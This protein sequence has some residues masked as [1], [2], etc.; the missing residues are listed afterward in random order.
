MKLNKIICANCVDIIDEF[1]DNSIKLVATS[2][3]YKNAYQSNYT[4][5]FG[6]P[7]Y[8][9]E[10]VSE[11]LYNKVKDNGIYALNLG[12]S[13]STGL[14]FPFEIVKR[15]TKIGWM[16]P[17]AVIWHKNNPIPNTSN[18]FTISYEFIFL[19]TKQSNYSFVSKKRKYIH[20]VW[21]IPI[22]SKRTGHTLM[23]PLE[24]PMRLIKLFTKQ[25]DLVVD[26]FSGSGQTVIASK[27]LNRKYI[28]IDINE[29]Y[30]MMAKERMYEIERGS[31]L[32]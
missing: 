30:C 32:K 23:F 27:M 19:L 24:I 21:D 16:V 26:P 20:N 7:L 25:N 9:I 12:Y 29:K 3:P 14:L 31:A 1:K 11:L 18:Q 5:E 8:L 10:D 15:L 17:D 22:N 13:N 28:G 6:E 2:P 4:K